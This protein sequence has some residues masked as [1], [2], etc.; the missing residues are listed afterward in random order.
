MLAQ[1]GGQDFVDADPEAE[2]GSY[3]DGGYGKLDRM[4][5]LSPAEVDAALW[6]GAALEGWLVRIPSAAPAVVVM[7]APTSA[8][9]AAKAPEKQAAAAAK[10]KAKAKAAAESG[11]RTYIG[12]SGMIYHSQHKAC[13]AREM[14]FVNRLQRKV[15]TPTLAAAYARAEPE[16]LVGWRVSVEWKEEGSVEWYY[17]QV[18][19]FKPFADATAA[20]DSSSGGVTESKAEEGHVVMYDD[21]SREVLDLASV[22]Y[23]LVYRLQPPSLSSGRFPI[24][25]AP[26]DATMFSWPILAAATATRLSAF[27]IPPPQRASY[28]ASAAASTLS[29]GDL[30]TCGD[31]A[32]CGVHAPLIETAC[33]ELVLGRADAT[34]RRHLPMPLADATCRRQCL[35]LAV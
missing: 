16:S 17:G 26:H 15:K 12:P 3:G 30:V 2:G 24:R 27:L 13:S 11:A 25:P 35:P 21:G 23:R 32:G 4:P 1:E 28:P 9:E 22:K 19:E 20:T 10:A 29:S 7:A 5:S 14:E 6:Q 34:C 18:T 8:A 31:L 33:S